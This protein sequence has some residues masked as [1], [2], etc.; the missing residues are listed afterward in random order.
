ML[1]EGDDSPVMSARLQE[2]GLAEQLR[3]YFL[4][5]GFAGAYMAGLVNALEATP[6]SLPAVEFCSTV[7]AKTTDG[8]WHCLPVLPRAAVRAFATPE[9]SRDLARQPFAKAM[10]RF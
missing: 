9:V 7:I 2:Q 5:I 10:T 6:A 4:L 3:Q 8:C 1:V